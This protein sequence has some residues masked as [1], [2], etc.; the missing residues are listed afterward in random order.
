M[1]LHF[2]HDPIIWLNYSITVMIEFLIQLIGSVFYIVLF[3]LRGI[4]T[5]ST[6]NT[7]CFDVDFKQP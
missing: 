5:I 6:S 4:P 3:I 1:E 7:V 2:S